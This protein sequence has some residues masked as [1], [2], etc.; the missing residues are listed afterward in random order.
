MSLSFESEFVFPMGFVDA[1]LKIEIGSLVPLLKMVC[2][3]IEFIQFFHLPCM[4]DTIMI[5][6]K[7][8][9]NKQNAHMKKDATKGKNTT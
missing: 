4:F 7:P 5:R 1:L 2:H 8:L 6:S 3:M 9:F